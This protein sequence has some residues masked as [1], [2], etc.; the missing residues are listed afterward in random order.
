[1]IIGLRKSQKLLLGR[2]RQ[3]LILI[4]LYEHACGSKIQLTV[5]GELRGRPMAAEPCCHR[6]GL[7][8]IQMRC[9][10]TDITDVIDI[11]LSIIFLRKLVLIVSCCVAT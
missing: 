6:A 5:L 7:L 8:A 9:T 4:L 10:T 1:M 2:W 3:N 11:E